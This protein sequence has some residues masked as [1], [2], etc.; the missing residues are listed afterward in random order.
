MAY[1]L[2]TLAEYIY[3]VEFDFGDL[4]RDRYADEAA[5]RAG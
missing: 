4:F 1:S 2:N 5:A 3:D